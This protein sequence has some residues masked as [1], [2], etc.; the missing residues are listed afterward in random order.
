[1]GD[2][3]ESSGMLELKHQL[4]DWYGPDLLVYSISIGVDEAADKKAGFFDV[5]DRQVEQVCEDLKTIPGL[6]VR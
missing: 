5:I 4:A 1:M 3:G 2:S 6:K